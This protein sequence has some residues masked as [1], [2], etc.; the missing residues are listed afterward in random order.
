MTER[1]NR[2]AGSPSSSIAFRIG[3]PAMPS[4]IGEADRT[5]RIPGLY[6]PVAGTSPSQTWLFPTATHPGS[7]PPTETSP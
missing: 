4:S 6:T 1:P 2:A 5:L 7:W 3:F